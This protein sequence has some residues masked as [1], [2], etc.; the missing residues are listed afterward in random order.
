MEQI[1]RYPLEE[2]SYGK[3]DLLA[4]Q[5][6]ACDQIDKMLGALFS[7]LKPYLTEHQPDTN[8]KL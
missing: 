3:L 5:K 6:Q 2:F 4:N 1:T 7:I 8:P